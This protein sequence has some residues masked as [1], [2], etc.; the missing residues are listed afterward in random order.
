ML[1]IAL[2]VRV[3]T[4]GWNFNPVGVFMCN[5]MASATKGQ[6]C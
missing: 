1:K 6:R 3:L 5:R 2:L 4:P